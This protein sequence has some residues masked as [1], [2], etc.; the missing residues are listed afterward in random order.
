MLVL[1]RNHFYKRGPSRIE[2]QDT[3]RFVCH[4]MRFRFIEILFHIFY[5]YFIMVSYIK[6]FVIQRFVISRLHSAVVNN[7]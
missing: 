2:D 6:E 1:H 5:Y 7:N 3:D 4:I